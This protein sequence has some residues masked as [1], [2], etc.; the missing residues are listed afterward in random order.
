VL[1]VQRLPRQSVLS[2]WVSSVRLVHYHKY[3]EGSVDDPDEVASPSP[4]L[5]GPKAEVIENEH[6]RSPPFRVAL[7]LAILA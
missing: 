1:S 7:G 2:A 3:N 6:Y 4:M 5:I